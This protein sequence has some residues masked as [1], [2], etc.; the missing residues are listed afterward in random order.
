M[1]KRQ[2]NF[3][4]MV[5]IIIIL[6]GC[7]SSTGE[8]PDLTQQPSPIVTSLP[9]D[10]D[11]AYPAPAIISPPSISLPLVVYNPYPGPSEGVTNY[12]DWSVAEEAIIN[13]EIVEA[14]QAHTLHVT[15]VKK[16]GALILSIEP[17]ID[18]VFRV[19]DRC[20]DPCKDVV[21]ATE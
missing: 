18:E 16:D 6:I 2:I 1:F 10:E 15:L 19:L 7:Q 12:V 9:T 17:E 8:R 21:R 14:Y 13:G 11:P 4:I 20:G 5:V 3:V